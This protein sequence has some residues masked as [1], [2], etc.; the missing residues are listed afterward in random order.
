MSSENL[1]SILQALRFEVEKL[2]EDNQVLRDK[3]QKLNANIEQLR[4]DNQVLRDKNQV[5]NANIEQ[6]MLE[7]YTL[8]GNLEDMQEA[9]HDIKTI[10]EK[11]E[12]WF[13][14]FH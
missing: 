4:E 11:F 3:N 7:R 2:K 10:F 13:Y 5:S 6:L 14:V 1:N 12:S 8:Q 9:M